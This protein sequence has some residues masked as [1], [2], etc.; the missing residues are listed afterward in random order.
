MKKIC[1]VSALKKDEKKEKCEIEKLNVIIKN[2]HNI[3]NYY[4]ENKENS[5]P[6]EQ[7]IT[8]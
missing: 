3:K 6:K 4:D 2:I 8:K 5:H 7:D 1:S